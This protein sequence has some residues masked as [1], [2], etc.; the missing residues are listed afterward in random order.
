MG[1]FR[2][3]ITIQAPR[4]TV[5]EVVADIGAID[6]WNPGVLESHRT[7]Q[8]GDGLG[9]GRHCDLGAKNYLVEEVVEWEPPKRLTMRIT[10]TNLPF[11]TAD[12][13]FTL[14]PDDG[15]TRVTVSPL[16][17]LRFG[18]LGRLLDLLFVRRTYRKGMLALLQGLKRYVEDGRKGPDL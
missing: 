15:A 12:I 9:A 1:T 6:R 13:R 11:E 2:T 8:E 16:Y 5:W 3:A 18:L 4:E 7:T 14:E 10:D 17:R